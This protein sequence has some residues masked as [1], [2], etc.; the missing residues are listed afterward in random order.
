MKPRRTGPPMHAELRHAATRLTIQFAALMTLLLITVLGL[1]LVLFKVSTDA[2]TER[3]L[4]DASRLSTA[5]I[6]PSGTFVTVIQGGTVT[7]PAGQPAGLVDL[8]AARRVTEGA[9]TILRERTVAG[10]DYTT[11]TTLRGDRVIQVTAE[12]HRNEQ[13]LRRLASVLV[14]AGVAA[15]GIAALASFVMARRAIRP[16]AEA[17]AGQRRFVAAASHELRT[18]LTLLST[19]AQLLGRRRRDDLPPDVSASLDEMMRDSRTLTQILDDLL[20]AADPRHGTVDEAV[21]LVATADSVISAMRDQADARQVSLERSGTAER[22]VILGA[23]AALARLFT[24]L[25]ANAIEHAETTVHVR[26]EV[27]GRS[28]VVSVVD[29]GPG[30]SPELAPRA[31]EPFVTSHSASADH[32]GLGLAIV[33]E[34]ARRHRGRVRIQPGGGGAVVLRLP[35]VVSAETRAT[36][37]RPGA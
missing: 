30:F 31:F 8:A 1:I 9:G 33:A 14:L 25:L 16:M 26:I 18:P 29:D 6:A 20:V 12:E 3:D 13:N 2:V 11:R 5:Q 10:R 17:L 23:A 15:L 37:R 4:G 34:I 22:A 21:D 28:A 19:R 27:A 36:G 24:A 7:A 32:F 35:G